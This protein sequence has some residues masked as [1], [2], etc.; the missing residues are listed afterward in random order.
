MARTSEV[1]RKGV[2]IALICLV[3]VAAM[4]GAAYASVPLYR[5]FCQATGF[6]GTVMRAKAAPTRVLDQKLTVTFDTNVRGVPFTFQAEQPSQVVRIGATG[7]AYFKVTN[8]SDNPVTARAAYNVL[9]ESAALYLRKLQCFCFTEQTLKAHQTAEFPMI[10]FIEPGFADDRETR[11][12]TDIT[13]SYTFY[14]A[15]KAAQARVADPSVA[16]AGAEPLG[17]KARAGL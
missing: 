16:K 4:V 15:G 6:G 13:L 8:T 1:A 2:R 14:P 7:M 3:G 11:T 9:P 5:A 12:F 10:Y 17:G